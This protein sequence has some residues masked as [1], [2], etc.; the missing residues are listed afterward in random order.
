[1]DAAADAAA[2]GAAGAVVGADED[3]GPREGATGVVT[4]QQRRD[5]AEAALRASYSSA[6]ADRAFRHI[7]DFHAKEGWAPQAQL[8]S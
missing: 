3:R 8:E 6:E 2:G 5:A 1:M 7:V 4:E